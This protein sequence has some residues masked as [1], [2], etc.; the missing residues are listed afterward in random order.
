MSE[1]FFRTGQ[2]FAVPLACAVAWTTLQLSSM[3]VEKYWDGKPSKEFC[4]LQ[5]VQSVIQLE[6]LSSNES[7]SQARADV[8]PVIL[9]VGNE[10]RCK[11]LY[12]KA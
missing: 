5:K 11:A 9:R 12:A 6:V 7:M 10:Q 4:V 3:V 2:W 8:N 1:S